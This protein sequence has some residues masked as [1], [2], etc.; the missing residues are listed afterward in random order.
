MM[1][2]APQNG[3]RKR[4]NIGAALAELDTPMLRRPVGLDEADIEIEG[5]LSD[6]RAKVDGQRQRIA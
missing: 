2:G 6:R 4:R 3:G 1:G 5:A